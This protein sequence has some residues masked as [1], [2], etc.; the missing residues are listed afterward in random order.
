MLQE[1]QNPFRREDVPVS[2]IELIH[3]NFY[4]HDF[5]ERSFDF[6]YSVGVLGEHAPFDRHVCAKLHS[7]LQEGGKLY[8][9]VV[10]IE[11]RKN[12]KRRFAEAA[13]PL[14][15][16]PVKRILDK[17]WETIYMTWEQL[18]DIVKQQGF[19]SYSIRRHIVD[20]PKWKG[21][22]LECIALK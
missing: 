1:A 19:S 18:E 20:D 21:V 10:D 6:I 15:P 16:S 9:T 5:G 17:R 3:G 14:L 13:Y 4:H 12:L 2:E 8:F 7:L 11:P 22:H